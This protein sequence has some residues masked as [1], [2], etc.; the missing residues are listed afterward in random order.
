M[1]LLSSTRLLLQSFIIFVTSLILMGS[2]FIQRVDS[3]DSGGK[4]LDIR[5]ASSLHLDASVDDGHTHTQQSVKD[6]SALP[7]V[8]QLASLISLN[9]WGKKNPT[10]NYSLKVALLIQLS[11]VFK[12]FA[13]NVCLWIGFVFTFCG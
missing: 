12:V 10:T 11:E 6:A 7:F 13:V 3:M 1:Q 2:H 9:Y 4:K 5:E 8:P